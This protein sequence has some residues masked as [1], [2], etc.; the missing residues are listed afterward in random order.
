MAHASEHAT[1]RRAAPPRRDSA[2][3][4]AARLSARGGASPDP[5]LKAMLLGLI[6]ESYL[7][8]GTFTEFAA[9]VLDLLVHAVSVPVAFTEGFLKAYLSVDHVLE[10]EEGQ[11]TVVAKEG[12]DLED[13]IRDADA[14]LAQI[15]GA[16]VF[17][18]IVAAR[19]EHAHLLSKAAMSWDL[20]QLAGMD[21]GEL[22]D[23]LRAMQAESERDRLDGQAG[24]DKATDHDRARIAT[25]R[26]N[27]QQFVSRRDAQ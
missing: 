15:D 3:R 5:Y 21:D 26:R 6:E 17:N 4:R 7:T 9:E 1:A 25:I 16:A 24:N 8:A 10:S 14:L 18:P 23:V 22:M 20:D 12:A 11:V 13:V 2:H 19:L 27:L